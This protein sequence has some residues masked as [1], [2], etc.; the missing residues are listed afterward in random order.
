MKTEERPRRQTPLPLKLCL[1]LIVQIIQQVPNTEESLHPQVNLGL[2]KQ[3]KNE[4]CGKEG[5]E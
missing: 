5:I 2:E 3:W 4:E 1:A